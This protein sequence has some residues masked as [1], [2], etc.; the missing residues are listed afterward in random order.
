M[1]DPNAVGEDVSRLVLSSPNGQILG[2]AL[3]VLLQRVHPDF[4][5]EMFGCRN[6]R[7]FIRKYATGV[8]EKANRGSDVVYSSAQFQAISG[9]APRLQDSAAI[10]SNP[11]TVRRLT[12]STPVWKTFASPNAFYRIFVSRESGDFRVLKRTEDPLSDPWVQVQSCSPGV[13]LQI[14]K[15]FVEN[16]SS[17]VAKIELSKTLAMSS[18]WSHF[19]VATRT[20]G[21]ERLWSA[22]RRRR[23][24]NEFERQLNALGVPLPLSVQPTTTE[25]VP[26][27]LAA[28]H[29]P[30]SHEDFKLRRI[31]A[32]VIGRLPI[33]DLRKVW[34]P[35]GYVLDEIGK[36]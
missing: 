10:Y 17:E 4:R 3:A 13:H 9:D 33:S 1:I 28:P 5:P 2:S 36:E 27:E 18:W 22:F 15:E 7:D 24:H 6:L 31:A 11:P 23:L 8:F 19:F 16:L 12:I 25:S 30:D 20:F 32:A 21:V 29:P 34:L 14:A 35:L 26:S